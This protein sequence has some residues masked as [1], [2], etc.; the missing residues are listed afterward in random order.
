[1]LRLERHSA[2]MANKNKK[3]AFMDCD[4][5]KMG[6]SNLAE[7]IREKVQELHGDHGRASITVGLRVIYCNTETQ[8]AVVCCRHGP[9]RLLA[10]A[11]PFITKVAE[12]KVVLTTIYTGAT[13]RHCYKVSL[14]TFHY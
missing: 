2:I 12:E 11:M 6:S 14:Q 1:M 5:L 7:A 9:H 8:M 4:P 3:R 10:A 13:V